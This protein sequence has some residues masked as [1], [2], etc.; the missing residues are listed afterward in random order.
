[1]CIRDR[2]CRSHSAVR[3]GFLSVIYENIYTTWLHC[4]RAQKKLWLIK[5]ILIAD[6]K[7]LNGIALVK[8]YLLTSYCI[9]DLFS[10]YQRIEFN[11][12]LP[13]IHPFV[14]FFLISSLYI[15]IFMYIYKTFVFS[16]IILVFLLLIITTLVFTRLY[17]IYFYIFTVFQ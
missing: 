4:L 16:H 13:F 17:C 7:V 12:L 2:L 10:C 8:L 3:I 1:M 6:V 14:K 9:L 11:T 15:F 5:V